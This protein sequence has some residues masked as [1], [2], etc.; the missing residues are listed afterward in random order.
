MRAVLAYLHAHRRQRRWL[1]GVSIAVAV[2]SLL[3]FLIVPWIARSVLQSEL[4]EA[5]G[6]TATI[7]DVRFN[8]YSL[9]AEV[10]RLAIAEAGS[11][12]R[13]VGFDLLRANLSL[14]SLFRWAL[15]LEELRLE[16]PFARVELRE[17]GRFNFSD[18]VDRLAQAPAEPPPPGAGAEA[19]SLPV[20]LENLLIQGGELQFVDAP[21]GQRHVLDQLEVVLPL[22]SM[23]EDDR[24]EDVRPS[25]KARLDGRTLALNGRSQPFHDTLESAFN[26]E[27][28][29]LDLVPLWEYVPL[30]PKPRLESGTL[31]CRLALSFRQE[32]RPELDLTG[33]VTVEGVALSGGAQEPLLSFEALAVEIDRFDVFGQRLSLGAVRLTRPTLAVTVDPQGELPALRFL[34]PSRPEPAPRSAGE[35]FRVTVRALVLE[36]GSVPFADRRPGWEFQKD[37][38]PIQLDVTD[39]DSSAGEAGLGLRVG[40]PAGERLELQGK[41]AVAPHFSASGKL[42]LQA[43]S[44]PDYA[45]Y[46]RDLPALIES[47]RLATGTD[48]SVAL[49]PEAPVELATRDGWLELTG[50]AVTSPDWRGARLKWDRLGLTGLSFALASR[51]AAVAAIELRKLVLDLPAFTRAKPGRARLASLKLS[52]LAV[53][54]EPPRVETQAIDL[55]RFSVREKAGVELV[56]GFSSAG[57]RGAVFDQA[58]ALVTVGNVWLQEPVLNAALEPSGGFNVARVLFG[59][60]A[61]KAED[62][63]APA[64]AAPAAEPG[65]A[66]SLPRIALRKG[67]VQFV[68]QNLTPPFVGVLKD[69]EV[70]LRGFSTLPGSRAALTASADAGAQG[71]IAVEGAANPNDRGLNPMVDVKINGA[72]VTAFSPYTL[73]FISHPVATGKLD[74]HV[75]LE[76]ADGK[77]SGQNKAVFSNFT[78]GDERESPDDVGIPVGLVLMLVRDSDNGIELDVPV[79]G[80]LDDPEFALGKVIWRAI[81]N[82]LTKIVTSP[83]TF[84]ASLVGGEDIDLLAMEPGT[85]QLQA[86]SAEKAGLLIQAMKKR[87]GVR[88]AI[89]PIIDPALDGEALTRQRVEQALRRQKHA[90]LEDSGAPPT[91]P[92]DVVFAP[93]ERPRLVEQVAL[94]SGWAAPAGELTPE[95]RQ[96]SQEEFLRQ[97]LAAGPEQLRELGLARVEVVMQALRADPAISPERLFVRQPDPK[98]QEKAAKLKSGVLIDIR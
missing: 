74:L 3:G 87:P 42:S 9:V 27:L 96:G 58:A 28:S 14:S 18:V 40:A 92:A 90:E 20:M 51:E 75:H 23:R 15:V 56:V 6:R 57:L 46:L 68:D 10:E 22:V 1:I 5:L 59:P 30:D 8:P 55:G 19:A 11:A 80:D 16:R 50:V 70:E 64:P 34:P 7:E 77:L 41:F 97:S 26:F 72:D 76:V 35:P 91:R 61:P 65:P 82:V 21:R 49:R 53:G 66:F 89:A 88:L 94:A 43:V 60:P 71:R 47:A 95:A 73:R 33:S 17:D 78:L 83:F 52:G 36:G 84:L 4:T 79:S 62:T 29:G 85:T 45:V 67:Q 2:Y 12:E 38:G 93:A 39:F 13:F 98:D 44:V 31:S 69:L 37:V 54:L 48:F 32:T 25:V 63:P 86:G 81:A 24:A